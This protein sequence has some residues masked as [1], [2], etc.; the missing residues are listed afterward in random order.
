MLNRWRREARSSATMRARPRSIKL[1]QRLGGETARR[2]F[3]TIAAAA[4]ASRLNCR[5]AAC[6][7]GFLSAKAVLCA[8]SHV[9]IR[10][11]SCGRQQ[12]R[13]E[14]PDVDA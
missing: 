11:H 4:A 5:E 12:S 2:A 1:R 3:L 6:I 13:K 14:L 7:K 9:R 10:A 8:S